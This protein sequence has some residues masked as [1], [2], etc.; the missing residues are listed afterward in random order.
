MQ[1]VSLV[2]LVVFCVYLGVIL[3]VLPWWSQVWDKNLFFLEHPALWSVMRL[4][5]IR[6][7]VSGLGLLDIWIGVTEAIHY[8]EQRVS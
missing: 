8:R 6:G 2:I 7:I 5:A 4:G 1:R 3:T